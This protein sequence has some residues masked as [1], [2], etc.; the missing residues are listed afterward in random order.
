MIRQDML[1]KD[2]SIDNRSALSD[3]LHTKYSLQ[4]LKEYFGDVPPNETVM[5]SST[6]IS[7]ELEIS[8]VNTEFPIECVRKTNYHVYYSVYG[9]EEG[10][11]YYVFWNKYVSISDDAAINTDDDRVY[12]YFT[13]YISSLKDSADFDDIKSEESTAEDVAKIDSAFELSFL[14]SSG[15]YSY[16]LL[17]DGNVLM[18][19]YKQPEKISCRKDLIVE[20]LEVISNTT[21]QSCS[22]LAC[23]YPDD[24]PD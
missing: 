4:D 13:A 7:S 11:L 19:K 6:N 10:G 18:I 1:L 21:A 16:S 3:L 20:K 17:T 15:I 14:M 8:D 2:Y 5:Y 22:Y 24:L 12:V 9:V 23:I